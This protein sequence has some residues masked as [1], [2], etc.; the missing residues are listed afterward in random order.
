MNS[1]NIFDTQKKKPI[2]WINNPHEG[3]D[4][5]VFDMVSVIFTDGIKR[6]ICKSDIVPKDYWPRVVYILNMMTGD[7]ECVGSYTKNENEGN[8]YTMVE[9]S[10]SSQSWRDLLKK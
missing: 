9:L 4:E 7:Y 2:F 10:S 5:Y 6:F 8:I 1:C 3:P